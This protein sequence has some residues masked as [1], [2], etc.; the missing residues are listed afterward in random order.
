MQRQLLAA[1]LDSS[2]DAATRVPGTVAR[3]LAWLAEPMAQGSAILDLGCGPGLYARP[4]ADQGFAVT[5]VDFN[6][7]S[8]EHARARAAGAVRYVL[9]DYT[10]D[11]PDGPFDLVMMIFLDFGTHPP[12]VQRDLLQGIRARLRPGGRFVFDFLDAHAA[13][14]HHDDRTWEA[15]TTGGFWSPDPYLLLTETV[16]DRDQLAQRT[17]YTLVT[18]AGIRR[19]D[20]WE[21][22]FTDDAVRGMLAAA[23]FSG[24]DLHR[25]LLPPTDFHPDPVFAV[26]TA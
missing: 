20:V 12:A 11:M 4:L 8:V 5:G 10:R 21:H 2:H 6:A 7:A 26:A 15:S 24:V 22:C 23:G 1:H 25:G 13:E 17:H 18:E 16:A 3:T 14:A 9:A 19:F